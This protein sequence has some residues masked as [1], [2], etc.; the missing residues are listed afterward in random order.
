M[1]FSARGMKVSCSSGRARGFTQFAALVLC[2]SLFLFPS[3]GKRGALTLRSYETPPA[4]EIIGAYHRES[5][6][7]LSWTFPADKEDMTEDFVLLRASEGS[8]KRIALPQST[9]RSYSEKDFRN[10]VHY[11]YK[12]VA[13]NH[14]GML[15]RESNILDVTPLQ[16]PFPPDRVSFAVKGNALV[17]SWQ[18]VGK[19]VRYNVYRG[20]EKGK[21]SPSPLNASPLTGNSFTDTFDVNRIVYYSIRSVAQSGISNEGPPSAGLEV[22]PFS[23]VPSAPRGLRA[24]AAP[25]R[26]ILYWDEPQESWV[27]GFRVYRKTDEAS[28]EL[29]G[30][31]QIPTFVDMQPPL[32]ER[33]YRVTAVGPGKE[34][35]GAEVTG[36]IYRPRE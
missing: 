2:A 19:D 34:G 36:A 35:P 26:T 22:D 9:A 12:I 13:R 18:A 20:S 5:V 33:D 6:I 28:Y 30:H 24:F 7:T 27:T 15:G 16:P 25:D 29:I 14:R 8:F 1:P 3:C 31:T 11:R 4:P 10:G 21:Y 32:T 17:L 23:F